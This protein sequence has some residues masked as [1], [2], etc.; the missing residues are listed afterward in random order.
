MTDIE[1]S[2]ACDTEFDDD[3]ILQKYWAVVLPVVMID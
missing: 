1:F 3:D 2:Y